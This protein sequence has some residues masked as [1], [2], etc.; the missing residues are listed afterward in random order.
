MPASK[1]FLIETS[2]PVLA[3]E[4]SD[5]HPAHLYIKPANM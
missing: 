3:E 2:I 1:F 5:N 4:P